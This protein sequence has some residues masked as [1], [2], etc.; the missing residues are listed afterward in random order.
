MSVSVTAVKTVPA[1]QKLISAAITLGGKD[2]QI[3]RSLLGALTR[4]ERREAVKRNGGN[5]AS[6]DRARFLVKEIFTAMDA[7][8]VTRLDEVAIT[9]PDQAKNKASGQ[10][11]GA[12]RPA[13][14]YSR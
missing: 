12:V 14:S 10:R 9:P 1:A 13:Y 3:F 11:S 8:G 7:Q 6:A 4:K 2:A 5:Q